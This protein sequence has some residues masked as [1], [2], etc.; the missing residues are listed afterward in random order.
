MRI[1]LAVLAMMV[2]L[3]AVAQ[4][5]ENGTDYKEGEHYETLAEPVPTSTSDKIEVVE[6]FAYTCGHCY[7]F[8]PLIRAWKKEQ[9]DDVAVVQTPAM[10]NATMEAYARGFYTA[11]AM[12]LLDEVHMAVFTAV[13]QEGKQFRSAEQWADFLE[14]YG[15]DRE[16]ILKTFN[17]FG[18]TSQ[19]R[20]ADARVRG[21]KITGTPEMVVD[22]KYRVSSRM[23]GSHSEMLRVVDHLVEQIRQGAL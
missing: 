17:S 5:P 15:A 12:E 21:Y 6:V 10:W 9:K 7:N 19:V 13:H 11:K 2:S 3:T 23:T 1:V 16:R 20:Q 14:T 8:E 18:I 4:T 22:G